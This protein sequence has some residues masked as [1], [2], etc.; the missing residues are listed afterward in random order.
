M[1][2][3]CYYCSFLKVRLDPD[4]N[5]HKEMNMLDNGFIKQCITSLIRTVFRENIQITS[6]T[7]PSSVSDYI[8][9]KR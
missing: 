3:Q 2:I 7:L 5:K 9:N 4:K 1:I 8:L 6:H